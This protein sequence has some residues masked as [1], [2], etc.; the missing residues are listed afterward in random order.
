[1][2]NE[3]AFRK[4]L[5]QNGR[6]CTK[7]EAVAHLRSTFEIGERRPDLPPEADPFR[8]WVFGT[9][10]WSGVVATMC[11][12]EG[13]AVEGLD[14]AVLHGGARLDET[15]PHTGLQGPQEHGLAGHFRGIVHDDHLG[16]AVE[17]GQVVEEVGQPRPRPCKGAMYAWR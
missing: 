9:V 12:T 6:F 11:R 8:G 7:R 15:Q 16:Q 17:D 1:M 4:P 5:G 14:G 10:V 13:A 2:L 3:A